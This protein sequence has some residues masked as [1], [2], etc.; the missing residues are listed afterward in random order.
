[1]VSKLKEYDFTECI[2]TGNNIVYKGIRI[3]DGLGVFAKET[4]CEEGEREKDIIKLLHTPKPSPL[5]IQ[6][7]DFI[8]SDDDGSKVYLIFPC[9]Q[10]ES[11]KQL[12]GATARHRARQLLQAIAHCHSHGIVH[13]DVKPANILYSAD[14]SLVL[15]DFD[16]S[17]YI[18]NVSICQPATASYGAPE[19]AFGTSLTEKMDVWSAAVVI[20]EWL[21]GRRIFSAET[22]SK[23]LKLVTKFVLSLRDKSEFV[24]Q[25]PIRVDDSGRADVCSLLGAMFQR[26]GENRPSAA[27]CLQSRWFSTDK[28]NI[29]A[30][31]KQTKLHTKTWVQASH[32]TKTKQPVH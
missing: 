21:T 27:E 24:P 23:E 19:Y 7:L 12:D 14:G 28:P 8:V 32:P 20:Y 2:Y 25:F 17:C 29:E 22:E 31:Q 9:L 5:I 16:R 15:A 13:M 1:M 6:L 26:L 11:L 3:S 4:S 10:E 18:E 30:E